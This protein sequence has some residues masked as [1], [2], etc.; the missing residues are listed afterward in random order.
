[1]KKQ[2]VVRIKIAKHTKKGIHQMK[3]N[4]HLK[5][6]IAIGASIAANC[7]PCLKYHTGKAL[8]YGAEES[9]IAEAIEVGTTVRKGAAAN[10]DKFALELRKA[11]VSDQN[12][13]DKECGCTKN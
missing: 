1:V 10:M 2:A 13:T 5:E 8:E 6:L 4:A 7:Q 11:S 3:L 9:E 12:S